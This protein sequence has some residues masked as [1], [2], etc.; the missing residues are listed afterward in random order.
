MGDDN[1]RT[2]VSVTG[3]EDKM[4]IKL[5]TDETDLVYGMPV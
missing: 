5:P 1:N 2:S 4:G 3:N